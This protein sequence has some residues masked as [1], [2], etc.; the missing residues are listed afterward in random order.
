MLHIVLGPRTYVRASCFL[1]HILCCCTVLVRTQRDH[2]LPAVHLLLAF[3]PSLR[4]LFGLSLLPLP[5]LLHLWVFYVGAWG[6]FP[7]FFFPLSS[8]SL[9]LSLLGR[10]GGGGGG[11]V[12]K[13]WLFSPCIKPSSD[14]SCGRFPPTRR[15][16]SVHLAPKNNATHF[17][18]AAV[19]PNQYWWRH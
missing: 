19:T 3:F 1:W 2:Y 13:T 5:C 12:T 18:P 15:C 8:F 6:N 10:G 16:I 9:F 11:G 17:K 7:G 4:F 14:Y